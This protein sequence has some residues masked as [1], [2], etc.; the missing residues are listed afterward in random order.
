MASNDSPRRT[1]SQ[2]S[3]DEDK[4][5]SNRRLR[6]QHR[7]HSEAEAPFAFVESF[8][9]EQVE[10]ADR[11]DVASLAGARSALRQAELALGLVIQE[12]LD[13]D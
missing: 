2:A 1:D 13:E 3:G 5:K 6:Q 10:G 4:K 8:M 12:R 7:R 9:A 11:V